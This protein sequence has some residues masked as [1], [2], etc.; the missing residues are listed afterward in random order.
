MAVHSGT[1]NFVQTGV[2]IRDYF[3]AKAMQEL[4][5][6]AIG[7]MREKSV[8]KPPERTGMDDFEWD[9]GSTTWADGIA[10][11]AYIIADAMLRARGEV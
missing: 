5:E 1:E 3:A 7:R 10:S 11:E 2:S 6:D 4:T 8:Q 9:D